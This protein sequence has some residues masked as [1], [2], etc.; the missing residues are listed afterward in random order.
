M[1]SSAPVDKLQTDHPD[2]QTRN[3]EP[4]CD[5]QF[6]SPHMGN[7]FAVAV[8]IGEYKDPE[9]KL[10]FPPKDVQELV[11]VLHK[12]QG[13]VF[14]KVELKVLVDAEAT[15]KN[16]FLAIDWLR[17]SSKKDDVA[18]LFMAG[19]GCNRVET[20]DYNFLSWEANLQNLVTAAIP[21]FNIWGRLGPV[22]GKRLLILDTCRAGNILPSHALV[23]TRDS[24]PEAPQEIASAVIRIAQEN[25]HASPI[26]GNPTVV[27]VSA[28]PTQFAH[29]GRTWNNSAFMCAF[30]EG[31]RGRAAAA[32]DEEITVSALFNYVRKRV[33]ELTFGQQNPGMAVLGFAPEIVLARAPFPTEADRAL[34]ADV[35]IE[36]GLLGQTIR[37]WRLQ[38]QIAEDERTVH[39]LA[40]GDLPSEVLFRVVLLKKAHVEQNIDGFLEGSEALRIWNT[41]AK[42]PSVIAVLDAGTTSDGLPYVVVPW[43]QARTLDQHLKDKAFASKERW[44]VLRQVTEGLNA[45]HQAGVLYCGLAPERIR[46]VP[47]KSGETVARLE[48]CELA[49]LAIDKP[50]AP[51]DGD[52]STPYRAPEY[53]ST[54]PTHSTASDVFALGVLAQRIL[55]R[56]FPASL[57]NSASSTDG[58]DMGVSATNLLSGS[59]EL[60]AQSV[61]SRLD[62]VHS[63]ET[64]VSETLRSDVAASILPFLKQMTAEHPQGRPKTAEV[65][66]FF[67]DVS[68]KLEQ[69]EGPSVPELSVGPLASV[70]STVNASTDAT[71][72][73]TQPL[74][75]SSASS[76]ASTIPPQEPAPRPLLATVVE[77]PPALKWILASTVAM[78]AGAFL[79]VLYILMHKQP[80][81]LPDGG[82]GDLAVPP[83]VDLRLNVP[84]GMVV[85]A[86]GR[87]TIEAQQVNVGSFAID[88]LEVTN[89]EFA[90]WLSRRPD[91]RFDAESE[92]VRDNDADR[93]LLARLKKTAITGPH[94]FSVVKGLTRYPVIHISYAAAARY[95]S[96]LQKRLPTTDEWGLAARNGTS[97]NQ[98]YPWGEE[99]PD[100]TGTV[101]ARKSKPGPYGECF[102]VAGP[103]LS[104]VGKS[105]QDHTKLGIFDMG[106]NVAEWVADI[107]AM[108]NNKRAFRGGDWARPGAA[109][110][111]RA[112]DT[113]PF[114]ETHT[115]VGFRCA[116]SPL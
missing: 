81:L 115:S 65:L 15:E 11:A 64:A 91:T 71:V 32:G 40:K 90:E 82:L 73:T 22:D 26:H 52:P 10:R 47:Q 42:H 46:L 4:D 2:I 110:Q 95:C 3:L 23:T 72:S 111:I 68:S 75:Q 70:M 20:G 35:S 106:G 79:V 27:M 87:F 105:W 88:K 63:S 109:C 13:T 69:T 76:G 24:E 61:G 9:L 107:G 66:S 78:A 101:F 14:Q 38:A 112:P 100:C 89:Q 67:V 60:L 30:L 99:P 33:P 12:Q 85:F 16:I 18:L 29:E 80:L 108:N 102:K 57:P 37:G 34:P 21:S 83:K 84:D 36:D 6:Q 97:S 5:A 8:G 74:A 55:E 116:W 98:T 103:G 31:L 93:T 94:P 54:P 104:E 41:K 58:L 62:I 45:L 113:I 25:T 1:P 7:L 51:I 53:I 59:T 50:G 43:E 17:E 44:R 92:E 96:A 86:G 56:Y 49:R 114:D 28:G 48:E 19:H 39:F 77:H